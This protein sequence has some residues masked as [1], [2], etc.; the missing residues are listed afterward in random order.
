M[1]IDDEY[2][3]ED[4]ES[5]TAY[6]ELD[7]WADWIL[8]F[9]FDQGQ[10]FESSRAVASGRLG[11]G[12][13]MLDRILRGSK[14]EP[15]S[16]VLDVGTGIGHLALEARRRVSERGLV[17]GLDVSAAAL[18]MCRVEA[19]QQEREES[20]LGHLAL[21]VGD[22]VALPFRDETF[23]HVLTR[24]VLIYIRDKQQAAHEFRRVLRP[25][26]QVSMYEPINKASLGTWPFGTVDSLEL[27]PEH[28]LVTD[29]LSRN[30]RFREE[31]CGF[32]ERD[33]L[34]Y[35]EEAGFSSSTLIYTHT[36][37][38]MNSEPAYVSSLLE[39]RPNPGGLSIKE[40]AEAV[41]GE[42]AGEYM[43][44]LHSFLI[45]QRPSVAGASAIIS[46]TRGRNE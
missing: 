22:G 20:G 31:M 43:D 12:R 18:K 34:A 44:R 11:N 17:V 27:Q 33:L 10:S 32:D 3:T 24:S 4:G 21:S 8:R 23:D 9:G 45:K 40:A 13:Q 41:L 2:V 15:G 35:F 29:W 36:R 46:A 30:D 16:R 14:V 42:F 25:G 37:R 28:D 7:C 38:R 5:E 19:T 6:G 26:G 39:A 1:P